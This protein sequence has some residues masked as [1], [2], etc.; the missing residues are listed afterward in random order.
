MAL[1]ELKSRAKG[2]AAEGIE[3]LAEERRKRRKEARVS[4]KSGIKKAAVDDFRR[5]FLAKLGTISIVS[6]K[7]PRDKQADNGGPSF[8]NVG[9]EI[10]KARLKDF[11]AAARISTFLLKSKPSTSC[12]FWQKDCAMQSSCSPLAGTR[13]W[14]R[15][16]K[17]LLCCKLP[18]VSYTTAMSGSIAWA[19]ASNGLAEK[20]RAMRTL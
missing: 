2:A 16:R 17:R 13:N 9:V 4:L 12:A 8:R 3:M 15:S 18:W 19:R 10:I 5:E 6:P 7:K 14:D 20:Q 11:S 1:E